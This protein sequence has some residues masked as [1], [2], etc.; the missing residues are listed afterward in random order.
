MVRLRRWVD[1]CIVLGGVSLVLALP[2]HLAL[3][4]IARGEGDLGAE[5]RLLRVAA[6]A[7]AAFHVAALLT[8]AYLLR[9]LRRA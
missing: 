1:G 5:W 9:A 4:D 7:I 3:T 8:F 2:A 6:A